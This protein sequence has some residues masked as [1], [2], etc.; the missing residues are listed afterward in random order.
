MSSVHEVSGHQLTLLRSGEEYFPCLLAAIHSARHSIYLESYIFAADKVG[1]L[2][3]E[4]L[5]SAAVRE[6][7]VHVLL[8]GFGSAY[9][10]QAWMD[11]MRSFGVQLLKYRP[12]LARLTFRRQR[13]RRLHR[14]LVLI[15][16]RIAFVWGI[17]IIADM[18]EATPV[19]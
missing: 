10:P 8:D 14:K 7:E 2:V 16:E 18:S 12:E 11:E 3:K 1:R 5:E 17:N 15:D 9:L 6:V 4:A 19:T 13:L